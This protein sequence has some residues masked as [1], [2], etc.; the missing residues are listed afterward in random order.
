MAVSPKPARRR[1][2]DNRRG[3]PIEPVASGPVGI[4]DLLHAPSTRRT[5]I[6]AMVFVAIFIGFTLGA[7]RFGA[8][9]GPIVFPV[10]SISASLW[11]AAEL[12]TA[13]LLLAQFAVNGVRAFLVLGAAYA[14]S[15]LLT[16]PYLAFFPGLFLPANMSAGTEQ[17]SVTLWALWHFTFPL[18][19]GVYFVFDRRLTA[20]VIDTA[21]I[22]GNLTLTVVLVLGFVFV[23]TGLLNVDRAS[24]PHMVLHGRFNSAWTHAVAPLIVIL[25]T[26]AALLLVTFSRRPSKLQ[27][28]VAVALATAALDG[29]L[30]AL[31]TGRYTI[32]WY[33]GK[34]ETLT[35]ATIVLVMLLSE[36]GV[37]Y[38]RLGTMA[39]LDALTGL[40][41]R[42]AFDD[43]LRWV[44]RRRRSEASEL[45]FLVLD[46]DF[47]KGFND[48]YGHAA[49]DVALRRIANSI[50]D[51]LHRELDVAARFGGEE[52]VVLLPETGA[53]AAEHVAERIRH[54][55]EAMGITH[56][57]STVYSAVTVSIGVAYVDAHTRI[58]Q[59]NLFALADH[60]LYQAKERRN[61][62]VVVPYAPNDP[63][64]RDAIPRV[65]T[66]AE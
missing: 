53:V 45:S 16:I 23:V 42:R 11:G 48:R 43:Y 22:R 57:A 34:F 64:L 39:M 44:L 14:I 10:V 15:G 2:T 36:V 38:R 65:L 24:L 5:R 55:V 58:D 41:N 40:R 25:N 49:G 29:L 18:L 3:R 32:G 60:A 27:V 13:Y 61:R 54:G 17:I 21:Q 63:K 31:S 59:T 62:I 51:S 7:A 52:F 28:W 56:G 35:T 33:L 4:A 20:R 66:A 50:V 46:V 26:L 37:M 19:V 8:V 47:F 6:T 30:N 9:Q 1:A 12:L